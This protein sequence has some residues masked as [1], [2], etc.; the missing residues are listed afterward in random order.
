[1]AAKPNILIVGAG[2]VG[3]TAAVELTRRGFSPRIIEKDAGPHKESRALAINPRTLDILEPSGASDRLIKAGIKALAMNFHGPNE[4]LF[5]INIHNIPHKSRKYMLVLPQAETEKLLIATLGGM[6]RIDWSTELTD[7]S[8]KNGKP[9]VKLKHKGKT[10]KNNP[11]MVIGADGA[12]SLVRKSL[13]INFIGEAYEHDWGL[14]DAHLEG[15]AQEELHFFDLS[16]LLLGFIPISGNLF[17]I[18]ADTPNV[19]DHFP[20]NIQIQKVTW[21]SRFRISHRQVETYQRGGV[22]LAGDAAHIHSPV[23]GRGMNLGIEDA[24]WLAYLIEQGETQS[25]TKLRHP[26]A[27]QV[28][29]QVNKATSFISSDR[30]VTTFFRRKILPLIVQRDFVQRKALKNITG[31]ATP[32]PSWLT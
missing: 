7:L 10:E 31:L 2:P 15:L 9:T 28:L 20:S 8:L 3:L 14:A 4:L 29:E 23:G 19:F 25:Y 26:V 30:P 13:G 22:F 12:H 16:P 32:A 18:V 11:D 6:A 27:K 1:M 5:R 24:A 21:E 17:R